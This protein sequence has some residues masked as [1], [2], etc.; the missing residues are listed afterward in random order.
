MSPLSPAMNSPPPPPLV[1][2]NPAAQRFELR[3]EDRLALL[4][5]AVEGG[6]VS[7]NHTFV[8][9][10]LRGRGLAALLVRAALEEA[11]RQRWTVI[12]R[13]SYVAGFIQRHAEY[14][15]LLD[16]KA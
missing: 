7:L 11:R 14:A 8:P 3:V 2:H 4:E 10:E 16:A 6:R 12:A 1:Q 9:D 13:C 5:Y 15:D